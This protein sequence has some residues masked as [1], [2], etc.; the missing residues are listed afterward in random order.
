MYATR[1][2]S[3]ER[4]THRSDLVL[5]FIVDFFVVMI[6]VMRTLSLACGCICGLTNS[7]L[8]CLTTEG[9]GLF[10]FVCTCLTYLFEK[11]KKGVW[12]CATLSFL[13]PFLYQRT[14]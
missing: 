11:G 8:V 14:W 6:A 12:R 4:S 1:V 10:V 9:V 7:A 3:E 2:K 5:V 13:C